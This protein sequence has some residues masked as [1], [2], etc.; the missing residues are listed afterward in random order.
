MIIMQ[1]IINAT[2][3]IEGSL[4]LCRWIENLRFV[5]HAVL[6][7]L[8]KRLCRES[9]AARRAWAEWCS[10]YGRGIQNLLVR[11]EEAERF[12]YMELWHFC[13]M[14]CA[15]LVF[16]QRPKALLAQHLAQLPWK[17][18][19]I[20]DLQKLGVISANLIQ[21][22]GGVPTATTSTTRTDQAATPSSTTA[23]A[24][25]V[26]G[27]TNKS[28]SSTTSPACVAAAGAAVSAP[29][30]V[31]ATTAGASTHPAAGT[32][33]ATTGGGAPTT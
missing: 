17:E 19:S 33:A 18:E 27:S 15:R 12:G 13:Q 16:P 20:V 6:C 21:Q 11:E 5:N 4:A 7:Y 29:L 24:A 28:S 9:L 10:A 1:Q 2:S 22:H 14:I 26:A 23:A 31:A 3:L 30:G 8:T 32:S 25:N